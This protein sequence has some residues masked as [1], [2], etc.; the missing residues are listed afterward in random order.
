MAGETP[1][2]LLAL[3]PHPKSRIG[4]APVTVLYIEFLLGSSS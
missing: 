3:T 2:S 4:E 1:G